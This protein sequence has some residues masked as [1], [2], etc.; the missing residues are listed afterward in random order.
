MT[1]LHHQRTSLMGITISHRVRTDNREAARSSS[2]RLLMERDATIAEAGKRHNQITQWNTVLFATVRFAVIFK[3][4][5]KNQ[6]QLANLLWSSLKAH[7][8]ETS[9]F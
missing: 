5:R 8:I 7:L 9:T 2:R 4:L 3:C 6:K 1:F